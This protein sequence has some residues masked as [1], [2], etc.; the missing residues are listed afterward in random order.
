MRTV[1]FSHSKGIM[2]TRLWLMLTIVFC[3]FLVVCPDSHFSHLLSAM[4][5]DG[6]QIQEIFSIQQAINQAE[7]GSTI[8]IPAGTYYEH[9]I[10]NKSISLLGEDKLNTIIDGSNAGT[11]VE[12]GADNVTIANFTIRYS[13]WGWT[14]NGIYVHFANNCEIRSN[15]L[16][17]NCH[18]IRLNYSQGSLIKDNIIDG[19]GYGIRL[20][21]SN[22]CIAES[23]NASNCIGGIHLELATNCTVRKNY[24]TQ[25]NQAIRMYS[26]C[27]YNKI[28]ANTAYNNTYDGMIDDTMNGNPTFLGNLIFHNNFNDT[29]PFIFKGAGITWHNSYPTGG[30]YWSLHDSNDSYRGF[31]QNESGSDG[32]CDA[33]YTISGNAIDQYPLMYPWAPYPVHNINTG[34]GHYTI[35]AALDSAATVDGHVLWIDSGTYYENLNVEKQLT[36]V[37]EDKSTTIIDGGKSGVVLQ[38]NAS[39]VRISGLT[40]RNSGPNSPPY[41]MDCGILLNHVAHCEIDNLNV[42]GNQ[43]GIYLFYSTDNKIERTIVSSNNENGLWLWYSGNNTLNENT[44]SNNSYNF[45]VFG[46]NFQDFNNTVDPSNTVEG[47]P[48]QYLINS[49]NTTVDN[50]TNP[51]VV[52][53]INCLNVTVSDLSLAEN[54]HGVFGYNVTDCRI[55]DVNASNCNY[56]IYLQSSNGNIVERSNCTGDWVGLC[57][58]DSSHNS[59]N[60]N[61]AAFC[62]KGF[63]LYEASSNSVTGNDISNNL[64]GIRLFSSHLNQVFHNNLIE[65]DQQASLISSNQNYWDNGIEGNFWSNYTGLDNNRDG[66]GDTSLEIDSSNQDRYPLFGHFYDLA[67][68]NT[69]LTYHVG[70][71]TNSTMTS[72]AFQTAN[73]TLRLLMNGTG[74]NRGFCRI[75]IPHELIQPQISAILDGGKTEVT[76]PNYTLRNDG[77]NRWIYF[78]YSEAYEIIVVPE[79]ALTLLF[80]FVMATAMFLSARSKLDRRRN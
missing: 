56:G 32:I 22:N 68:E 73:N 43:W 78:A 11:V 58:Q 40:L 76:Y 27:T 6:K 60:T 28:T 59:L 4:D 39:Y 16:F 18:N 3:S 31:Y 13:G 19:N 33:P 17:I 79:S 2:V 24:F 63:S 14:N 50:E 25:N 7:N 29:N 10:I 36:L 30:N 72:F 15:Y 1:V 5:T 51:S 80:T 53:L 48:I 52:Y 41:G 12:I 70:V 20:L 49:T 55:T 8:H 35:E 42:S 57:L 62:E 71:I 9:V 61:V 47:K 77:Q 23:N 67:I 44:I 26:P 54:G 64:Y 74:E 37:G 45:G 65:N 46:E 21:N 75:C 69:G 34:S 66:L 38:A